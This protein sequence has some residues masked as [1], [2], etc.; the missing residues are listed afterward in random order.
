M[1]FHTFDPAETDRLEQP[2]RFRFCS[3]E[4]LLQWL[5]GGGTLLD[6]GSG[7]GFYTDELAP[8]FDRIVA[9]DLQPAMHRQY[10]E[11]GVPPA[12]RPVTGDAGTLPF[13]DGA[14]DGAVSTMTFHESTTEEGLRELS[15][16]LAGGGTLVVVDWSAQG[17]GESGPPR[18][19]RFDAA[20][21]RSM[22]DDAGFDVG[23]A[24]ERSET[25]FVRAT[26]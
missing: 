19:E 14:F 5:P 4:E 17:R 18:A 11:R 7:T 12:V 21:A 13:A 6:L 3:R 16:V 23:I 24:A 25:L 8:F 22:L 20:D 9:F 1:G 2:T 15:R 26:A 10:R